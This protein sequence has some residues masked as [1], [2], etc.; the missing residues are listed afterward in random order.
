MSSPPTPSPDA[1]LAW[2]RQTL[3]VEAQAILDAQ[4]RLDTSFVRAVERMLAC[5]GRVVVSGLGKTG[6]IARKIAATL[7]STGT[8][9]FFLH[10]AEAVH[11]DLGMITPD[12]VLIAISYSGSGAELLTIVPVVKRMGAGLIAMTGSPDSEL[13][14][15]A[16]V[17]LDVSVAAEA[18]PLNLAPTASTT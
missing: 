5:R 13:A 3:A 6:H 18:C 1:I 15:D 2:G 17:H 9:A 10:A 7:A 16:D 4:A 8:P 11:G 12:D 14:Q